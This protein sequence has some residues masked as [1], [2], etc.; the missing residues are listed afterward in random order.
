MGKDTVKVLPPISNNPPGFG[1][2]GRRNSSRTNVLVFRHINASL[3]LYRKTETKSLSINLHQEEVKAFTART[4]V[5]GF[6][7]L[8]RSVSR[9]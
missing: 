1:N 6:F 5:V 2:E 7:G 8:Y 9:V 4:K 3:A